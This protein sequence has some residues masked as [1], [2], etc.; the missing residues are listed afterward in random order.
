MDDN[1][2]LLHCIENLK[3]ITTEQGKQIAT[4]TANM[5]NTFKTME[6]VREDLK[7]IFTKFDEQNVRLVGV[8]RWQES[9]EKSDYTV[10]HDIGVPCNQQIC[11][12]CGMLM[13]RA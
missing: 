9:F 5:N 3:E 1:K 7:E 11:P 4:L 2:T 6:N 8:E 13:I 10:S 12:K